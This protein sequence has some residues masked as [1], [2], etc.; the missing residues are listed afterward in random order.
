MSTIVVLVKNVPDTWSKR[1]LEADFTLD[2]ANVDRVLDEINEFAMEQALRLKEASPEAGYRVVALSAGAAG[3][4]EALRKALSMG[5]DE[6][7]QLA[8]DALA[9]SDLLGTAWAL[10]NAINTIP[11]VSLIVTGSASSDGAMG[12]LPGVLAEY[13]Q[14]PALTNLSAVSLADGT[15]TATRIDNHGVYELQAALPAIVSISDKADKPRFPN[16]KGIMAAKKAEIKQLSLAEIGVAPEQVGLAHAATA[17]TA[18]ADRPERT[19]GDVIGASG[20]AAKIADYLAAENL[21]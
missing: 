10:N 8:D 20:A 16:F 7:I 15:V 1:T 12:A 21:I 14:V 3:A 2:R 11:D 6:A 9:G 4:D 13:R 5:A 19:Q 17:V 18:A